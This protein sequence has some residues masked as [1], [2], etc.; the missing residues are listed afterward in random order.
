MGLLLI[1]KTATVRSEEIWGFSVTQGNYKKIH[2]GT[3]QI[4]NTQQQTLSVLHL[5]MGTLH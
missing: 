5:V 4:Q 2:K 1:L 3:R